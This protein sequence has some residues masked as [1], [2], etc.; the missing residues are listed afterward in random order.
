[1]DYKGSVK[2]LLE[3]ILYEDADFTKQLLSHLTEC[4]KYAWLDN[5]IA[6]I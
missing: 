2:L 5:D 3:E 1:M 6:Q 4:E